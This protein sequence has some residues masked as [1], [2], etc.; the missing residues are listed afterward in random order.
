[1]SIT[2][3]PYVQTTTTSEMAQCVLDAT[4]ASKA[5]ML[6]HLSAV[7]GKSCGI[8]S[9]SNV[10]TAETY[11]MVSSTTKR[12]AAESVPNTLVSLDAKKEDTPDLA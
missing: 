7:L 1:M 9:A 12:L 3:N 2:T 6:I 4:R 11:S 5:P 10:K 8:A